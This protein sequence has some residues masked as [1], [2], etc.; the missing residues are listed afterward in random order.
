MSIY[1]ASTSVGFGW[2]SDGIFATGT[3]VELTRS[4]SVNAIYQRIWNEN[5]KTSW[6]S[7]YVN[8]DYNSNATALICTNRAK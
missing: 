8:I 3:D 4:W 6:F 2:I 5:W 1:N 7:S